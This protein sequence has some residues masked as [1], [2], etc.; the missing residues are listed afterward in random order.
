LLILLNRPF[1]SAARRPS[2]EAFLEA[3]AIAEGSTAD[4]NAVVGA[5]TT[6]A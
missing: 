4:R 1:L 3:T 6:S 5:A 2:G